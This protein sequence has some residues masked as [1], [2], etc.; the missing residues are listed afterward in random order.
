MLLKKNKPDLLQRQT[1]HYKSQ[2]WQHCIRF[3]R[4]QLSDCL[5]WLEAPQLKWH[6]SK[7]FLLLP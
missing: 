5:A 4:R 3:L 1:Y 2:Q 7:W 6:W